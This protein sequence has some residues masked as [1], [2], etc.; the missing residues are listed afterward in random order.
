MDCLFCKIVSGE[1]PAQIVYE[2]AFTVAFLDINP[3]NRGHVLVMPK[4]H[5]RDFTEASLEVLKNVVR[6][7]K[8]VSENLGSAVGADGF[9]VSTNNG[10]AADQAIMHLHFHIIP[11]FID[12]HLHSW[13]GRPYKDEQECNYVAESIIKAIKKEL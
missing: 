4:E 1:I 7:V 12:D 9:N 8:I 2:D 6:T 3:I 11:R 10:K 5:V 13:S